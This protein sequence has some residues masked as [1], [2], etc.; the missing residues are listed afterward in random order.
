MHSTLIVC[1]KSGTAII[2]M[3]LLKNSLRAPEVK[4]HYA[5]HTTAEC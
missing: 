3:D 1:Y 4:G 2:S 5:N